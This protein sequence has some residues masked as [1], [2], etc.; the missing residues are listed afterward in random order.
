MTHHDE[1]LHVHEL[2]KDQRT[3]MLTTVGDDGG[4]QSRPMTLLRADPDGTYWFLALAG[5]DP[6]REARAR[7]RVNVAFTEEG[8]W[9]SVAGT[10]EVRHDP[11]MARE[12]WNRFAEVWFQTGPDDPDV[13]VVRVDGESAQYWDSPGRVSSM[14]STLAALATGERPDAGESGTVDL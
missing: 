9:V 8:K 11:E 2:V 6:A 1:A 14:V 10:A 12:L 13:A 5:S 3:A 7:S 4:L